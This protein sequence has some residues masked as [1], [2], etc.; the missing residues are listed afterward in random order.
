HRWEIDPVGVEEDGDPNTYLR[1]RLLRPAE[2]ILCQVGLADGSVISC[3]ANEGPYQLPQEGEVVL[4][5]IDTYPGG[6]SCEVYVSTGY[7]YGIADPKCRASGG[8]GG[9]G[10]SNNPSGTCN[11]ANAAAVLTTG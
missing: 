8:S 4:M 5:S 11:A 1:C 2:S 9:S 10:G 6:G 7:K 3:N